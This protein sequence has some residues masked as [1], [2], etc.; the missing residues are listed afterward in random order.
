MNS[1]KHSGAFGDLIY[2]LPVVK[3]FG[4]GDFYLHL[5]QIDWV[6][7][8]YYGSPPN[9]FHQ[10][11]L[12]QADFEYM[13][14][15]MLAQTYITKFEVLNPKTSMISHNLDRFRAPFVRHPGNYV[16]IYSDVFGIKDPVEKTKIRTTPWLTVPTPNKLASLVVNRSERWIADPIPK[17]WKEAV[18]S[19]PS[20]VFIGLPQEHA[21]FVKDTGINID[22]H[23][24]ETLLEVASVIAAAD[25]YMGNQS[26]GLAVAIGL[27]VPFMCELRRD[28]PRERNECYFPN[29]PDGQYF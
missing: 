5:N 29:Q 16:D 20:A 25:M 24:T 18:E 6:G 2:S 13:K 26:S 9:P 7:Q 4:G 21:K 3:H 17:E 1:F 12:T 28:L 22:Y 23:P 8:H 11:R 19:A 10:G 27:G 14:E 15:F